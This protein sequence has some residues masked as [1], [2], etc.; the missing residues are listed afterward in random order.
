M[1]APRSSWVD[2]REA[3]ESIALNVS[4]MTH[5]IIIYKSMDVLYS[6]IVK[7]K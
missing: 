4:N 2:H 3:L 6:A 7:T 1:A 5:N